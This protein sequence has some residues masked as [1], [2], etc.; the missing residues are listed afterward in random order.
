MRRRAW[1]VT[2][3]DGTVKT[4]GINGD[5]SIARCALMLELDGIK[6]ADVVSLEVV[7]EEE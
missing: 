6:E 2:L 5:C 7:W 4:V 1:R 3:E